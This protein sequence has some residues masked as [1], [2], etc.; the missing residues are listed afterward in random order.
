MVS[1]YL[2]LNECCVVPV[3]MTS[4]GA[5]FCLLT[6]LAENRWEFPKL[7]LEDP[8]VCDLE[9]LQRA[10]AGAGLRGV[11]PHTEALGQFVASRGNETRS[12]TGY[13][14]QVEQVEDFWPQQESHRR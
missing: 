7:K 13:L 10:A 11:L 6:P 4:L 9:L 12:M 8:A 3:R 14:L 1:D 2:R 5:E